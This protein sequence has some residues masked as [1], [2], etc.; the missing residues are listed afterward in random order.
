ME[1]LRIETGEIQLQVNG[2]PTRIISFNPR[3]VLFAE[4]LYNLIGE[5]RE[6]Q[7]DLKDRQLRLDSV[8]DKDENGLPVNA[9][10]ILALQRDFNDYMRAKIDNIFG[11]G[12]SQTAFG[13]VSVIIP[14]NDNVP[15]AAEQ[16][17]TGVAPY[18]K[19]ARQEKV[20]KYINPVAERKTRHKKL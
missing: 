20:E 3:D 16:F 10:E 1:N 15:C 11:A 17:L 14:I 4:K 9:S 18:I 12:T 19:Q 8:T 13:D 2:D 7:V 6:K 5:L